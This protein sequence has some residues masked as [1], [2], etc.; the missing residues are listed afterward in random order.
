MLDWQVESDRI[1][2][3]AS[4]NPEQRRL[5][6]RRRL[7]VMLW[8]LG[9][10]AFIAVVFGLIAYRIQSYDNQLK[11]ELLDTVQAE[12]T[13]LR[14]GSLGSYLDLQ[15][16][17]SEVWIREQNATFRRYQAEKQSGK[18]RIPGQVIDATVDNQRGRAV[19]EEFYEDKP[20]RVVWYYWRYADG[21]RHVPS[22]YTFWG[23][24]R[25]IEGSNSL[26]RYRALDEALARALAERTE[27][28]W[29]EGCQI[30]PNPGCAPDSRLVIDIVANPSGEVRWR[31]DQPNTLTV[32]SPL[33]TEIRAD[34]VLS[35]V[36]EDAI[37]L[38]VA[39]RQFA[40]ASNNVQPEPASDALWLSQTISEWLAA[41]Y[42]GRGDA[43]RLGF[44]QT[45]YVTFGGQGL[46][47]IA[48]GLRPDANISVVGQ[49]LGQSLDALPGIDWRAFFQ[50]R[51]DLE[52]TLINNNAITQ[53]QLLWDA[54]DP[55]ALQL[56]QARMNRLT[57]S[58]G[59]VQAVAIAPG[60]DGQPRATVQVVIGGE[61]FLIS[62][63]LV[64]GNWKRIA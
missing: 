39:Q 36:L 6:R 62:F 53:L 26:V 60:P 55:N 4:E 47:A 58:S 44:V 43:A 46:S 40:Q 45:L 11:Q 37:A 25:T 3:R 1:Y 10:A 42:T 20:Y 56:L 5:R 9:A 12:A 57:E 32:P 38:M 50:Q 14:I 7:R 49:A 51:L 30:L 24:E 59:Q 31:G 34:P 63:R 64:E 28:W 21:W 54:N 61:P 29:A 48:R 15:R 17:A 8:T 2:E 22:D 16:S 27:R 13:A 35:F 41:R 33:A 52:K 18:V 23:E 19:V